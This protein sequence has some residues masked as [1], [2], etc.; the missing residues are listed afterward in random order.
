ML[1]VLHM[2]LLLRLLASPIWFLNAGE[3]FEALY[4]QYEAEGRARKV[5]KAQEVWFAILESQVE[6]GT[7]YMLYKVSAH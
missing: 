3:K 2:F 7:P 4:T 1:I 6:T 5:V